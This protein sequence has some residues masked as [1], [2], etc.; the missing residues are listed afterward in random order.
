MVT[1]R[2]LPPGEPGYS[3]VSQH[4]LRAGRGDDPEGAQRAWA[5]GHD[6]SSMPSVPITAVFAAGLPSS[7]RP[8]TRQGPAHDV[9]S[10]STFVRACRCPC[11]S[12][13]GWTAST[14]RWSRALCASLSASSRSAH[15]RACGH[16]PYGGSPSAIGVACGRL[17]HRSTSVDPPA[18]TLSARLSARSFCHHQSPPGVCIARST[19][20]APPTAVAGENPLACPRSKRT[21][22]PEPVTTRYAGA[23]LCEVVA[24]RSI[25]PLTS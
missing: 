2:R 17:W 13:W 21:V 20:A 10:R 22:A 9:W 23:S 15:A 7:A 16:Q 18:I 1:V 24:V 3:P 11:H 4:V 12:A 6:R 8:C 5:G 25:A 14:T 19:L